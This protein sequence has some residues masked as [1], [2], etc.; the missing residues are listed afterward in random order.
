LFCSN[1]GSSVP[2]GSAFCPVCGNPSG[3][4]SA[5]PSGGTSGPAPSGF[6][7]SSPVPPVPSGWAP[8][9]V[10][11]D[12]ATWGT[13]AIGYIIDSLLVGGAMIILFFVVGGV[14]TGIARL[15][16]E[17][18]AGGMCCVMMMLLPIA[19][20]LVGLYNRVYLVALRGASIGQGIMK[21]KVVDGNGQLLT[22]KAAL[23]RLLAQ[24]GL[25]LVPLLPILDML[26]PLWDERR[27][28]IHDK[29]VSCYV[30]NNPAGT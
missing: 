12:Y 15:G 27:Q 7:G 3:A 30:I 22:Q 14:L 2:E 5:R 8:T 28:T 19:S 24:V 16:G 21:I 10:V 4:G 1:C 26:W 20:L 11:F 23:I 6:G 18:A 29:A 25:G 13:R 17:N 9:G